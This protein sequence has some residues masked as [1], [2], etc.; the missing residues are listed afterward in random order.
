MKHFSK[1]FIICLALLFKVAVL[2]G[3]INSSGL[4]SIPIIKPKKNQNLF[5]FTGSRPEQIS[6]SLKQPAIF[7][8]KEKKTLG[9]VGSGLLT[10]A[11]GLGSSSSKEVIWKVDCN[12]EGNDSLPEWNISLFCEGDFEKSRERV[13][14][15][16]GSFSIE[17]QELKHLY[18]DKDATGSIIAGADTIGIF[19]I[20]MDPRVDSL[21]MP[22]SGD[23]YLSHDA[24]T[25]TGSGTI[26][27]WQS[28]VRDVDFGIIGTLHGR[29]FTLI[30][31]GSEFKTWIYISNEFRA[32]F[33]ADKDDNFIR[34]KDR[35][36]PY[37]L[38]GKDVPG[39]EIRELF[40]LA[41][42]SRFLSNALTR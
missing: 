6:F 32:I 31:N 4:D 2:T 28:E 37:L 12:I 21:L 5:L 1:I 7:K 25:T 10:L 8:Y 13:R 30:S 34:K 23:V 20:I 26:W 11:T 36:M 29:N 17:T 18:W 42:M 14:N 33:C 41:I 9:D 22:W 15:D 27:S 24:Q 39:N 3:Q 16:D 19:L 35:V 40:R 38:M